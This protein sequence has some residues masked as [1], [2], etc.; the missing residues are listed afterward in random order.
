MSKKQRNFEILFALVMVAIILAFANYSHA[1]SKKPPTPIELPKAP[2]E[3]PVESPVVGAPESVRA[4]LSLITDAVAASK[5]AAYQWTWQ[6]SPKKT[7]KM[8]MGYFKGN[9]LVYAKAICNRSRGDVVVASQAVGSAS[10]DLLAH[11]ADQFKAKGIPVA[12]AEDRL[13]ATFVGM[14]GSTMKESSGRWCVGRDVAA[15]ASDVEAC[16]RGKGDTCEAG[17]NQTS[18]NALKADPELKIQWAFYKNSDK[19]CFSDYF[20]AGVTCSDANMKNWGTDPEAVAWQ[21]K[22]KHCGA[23]AVETTMVTTR[24]LRS[25]YGPY[26]RKTVEI[27]PVCLDMLK[28]IDAIVAQWPSVCS[29][30]QD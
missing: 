3:K 17:Y 28:Q 6:D 4:S 5:C 2:V 21:K 30:L 1:F 27:A 23:Y 12:T 10:K 14:L 16:I 22:T 11:M 29:L 13:R 7:G 19:G 26:N 24:V 8:P 9:G 18:M 20:K 15:K 25:H